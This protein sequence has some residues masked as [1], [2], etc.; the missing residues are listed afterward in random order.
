MG[1]KSVM[2][3]TTQVLK[4]RLKMAVQSVLPTGI[5]PAGK[6]VPPRPSMPPVPPSM[7]RLPP[8]LPGLSG[9][10]APGGMTA[11]SRANNPADVRKDALDTFVKIFASAIRCDLRPILLTG[12]ELARNF[13]DLR[14]A[15]QA[16]SLSPE[17]SY[18]LE[19]IW[20]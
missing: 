6:G 11:P 16:G 2:S 14:N 7:P 3:L 19:A 20:P 9:I 5:V 4:R 13:H 12:L 1:V 17:V 15:H 10:P 18:E 8:T